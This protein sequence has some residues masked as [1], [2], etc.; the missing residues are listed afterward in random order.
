MSFLENFKEV[1]GEIKDVGF[2]KWVHL[3][4]PDEPK[5]VRD[6]I[7]ISLAIFGHCL[8]CTALSGCLFIKYNKPGNQEGNGLLHE[9]CHCFYNEV[10]NIRFEAVCPIDKFT[11]YI[12]SDKY[13]GNGKRELFETLGFDI[14]DAYLLKSEYERQAKQKY[15]SGD[16][17]LGKLSNYGQAIS[18][19][20]VLT[21]KTGRRVK[22]VSGWMVYPNG[23]I[24][25][26]TP[27][28]G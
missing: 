26:N 28:G 14:D 18:I 2:V 17:K 11:N 12:F 15:A 25:C 1:N 22:F 20:I 19:D 27:L 21:S 9:R 4:V 10:S 5:A 7:R 16:Y 8:S 13:M 24:N 23:L 3:G 6:M